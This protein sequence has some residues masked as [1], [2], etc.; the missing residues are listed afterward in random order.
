MLPLEMAE[1]VAA[2]SEH[3]QKAKNLP[4][5]KLNKFGQKLLQFG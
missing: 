5:N 2:I 4:A 3:N 1:N